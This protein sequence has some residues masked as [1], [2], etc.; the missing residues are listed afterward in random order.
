MSDQLGERLSSERLR[1][2]KAKSQ[3]PLRQLQ[4]RASRLDAV[5]VGLVLDIWVKKVP[6]AVLRVRE[7]N[8]CQLTTTRRWHGR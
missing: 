4:R 1:R 8:V 5:A 3:R 2:E 7:G 6:M